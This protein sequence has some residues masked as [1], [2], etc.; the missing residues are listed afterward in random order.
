M[1]AEEYKDI[2]AGLVCQSPNV[3]SSPSL[4][5]LTPGVNMNKSDDSL[6]QKY[7]NPSDVIINKGADIA[8]VGRGIYQDANPGEAAKQYKEW[9]WNTYIERIS[10]S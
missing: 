9:L 8:V 7:Q 2:V 1:I 5:Q 6:G 3:I 10:N 4:I